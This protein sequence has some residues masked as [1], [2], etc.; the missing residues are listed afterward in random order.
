M[1]T[2]F[3][4]KSNTTKPLGSNF[5]S[6]YVRTCQNYQLRYSKDCNQ[7][8]GGPDPTSGPDDGF[9][10]PEPQGFFADDKNCAKYWQCSNDVA[11]HHTCD[12]SK[13]ECTKSFFSIS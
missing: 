11:V 10:C 12:T 2:F 3:L 1:T 6:C 9:D 7:N 13:Q 8:C 4:S 5:I